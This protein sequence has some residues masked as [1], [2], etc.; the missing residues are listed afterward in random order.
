MKL[1]SKVREKIKLFFLGL[2]ERI[3]L[4]R[5]MIFGGKYFLLSLFQISIINGWVFEEDKWLDELKVV[6]DNNRISQVFSYFDKV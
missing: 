3:L 5:F 1:G 2:G 4:W 6:F